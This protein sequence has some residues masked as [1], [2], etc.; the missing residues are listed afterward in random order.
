MALVL[1][2]CGGR[3]ST[4]PTTVGP[5]G[6][7]FQFVNAPIEISDG[8]SITQA[9]YETGVHP[10]VRFH[11]AGTLQPIVNEAYSPAEGIV[12]AVAADRIDFSAS[13]GFA[14]Y[15]TGIVPAVSVGQRVT[16]RQKVGTIQIE[17]R[18]GY[19]PIGLGLVASLPN[20]G[21]VRPERLSNDLLFAVPPL[22]YFPEPLRTAFLVRANTAASGNLGADR[23]GTLQGL[24]FLENSPVEGST[25]SNRIADQLWFVPSFQ[26]DTR[27]SAHFYQAAPD[28]VL[29]EGSVIPDTDPQPRDVTPASGVVR[30]HVIGFSAIPEGVSRILMVQM[31]DAGHVRAEGFLPGS[32]EPTAFTPK[33][34]I[35]VR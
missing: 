20:P 10:E 30:F 26:T 15:L 19:S 17:S 9:R 4:A 29:Y 12:T 33:A 6:Q 22:E 7:A 13:G 16:P 11:A 18:Q 14:F 23:S 2:A 35:F 5:L 28:I 24:W 1:T 34:R 27:M 21:F 31:L 3:S 8:A 32:P 25:S